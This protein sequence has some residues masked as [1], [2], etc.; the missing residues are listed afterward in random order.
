[1]TSLT[2]CKKWL[3][4]GSLVA[5]SLFWVTGFAL[6]PEVSD[7]TLAPMAVPRE[8]STNVRP[9]DE[10]WG[11]NRGQSER[12]PAAVPSATNLKKRL[13]PGGG[14]E[15]DLRVMATL[16]EAPVTIDARTIQ[17][18]I[19]RQYNRQFKEERPEDLEE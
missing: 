10:Q 11:S 4:L 17:R 15:E 5:F 6:E 9:E 3:T 1:M 2:N 13:Y 19:F 18:E 7:E 12:E 14:D 8:D 16:P